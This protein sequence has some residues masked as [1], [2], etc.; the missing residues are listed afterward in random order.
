VLP[1]L[2]AFRASSD[3]SLSPKAILLTKSDFSKLRA[4]FT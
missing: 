1:L 2:Q 3:V 4:I